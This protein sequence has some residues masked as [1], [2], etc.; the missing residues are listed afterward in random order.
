MRCNASTKGFRYL[1]TKAKPID[2]RQRSQ[3][4]SAEEETARILALVYYA[5]YG[6]RCNKADKRRSIRRGR[7]YKDDE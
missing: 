1:L 4:K 3:L 7:T 6:L 2:E 5:K